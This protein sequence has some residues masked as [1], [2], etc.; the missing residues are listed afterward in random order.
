ML[1]GFLW[2]APSF[3]I[4]TAQAHLLGNGTTYSGLGS[5]TSISNRENA[6][7]NSNIV[8]VLRVLWLLILLSAALIVLGFLVY[9]VI[10]SL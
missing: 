1:A 7:Q 6:T 9:A 3:L 5:P 10:L 4:Q 8:S 2:L